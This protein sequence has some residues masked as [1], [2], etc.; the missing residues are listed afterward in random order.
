[1]ADASMQETTGLEPAAVGVEFENVTE[2]VE[3]TKRESC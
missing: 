1:M 2:N 3:A